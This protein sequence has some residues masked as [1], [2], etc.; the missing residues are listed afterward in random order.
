MEQ[1]MA[2]LKPYSCI[3]VFYGS[4]ATPQQVAS[5][6][7]MLQSALGDDVD[8]AVMDGGQPVYSF[9]ISGE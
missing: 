7:Q 6:E 2:T 8:V 3:T 1:L 5:V 4:D 9:I